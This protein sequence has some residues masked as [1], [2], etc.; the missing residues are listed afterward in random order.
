MKKTLRTLIAFFMVFSAF[1]QTPELINYQA[2]VRNATGDL[3]AE[4]T[5]GVRMSILQTTASGTAVYTETHTVDTNVNGALAVMIGGGTS[6]DQ[7]DA[8]D[9]SAG[10]Y[11]I[12]TEV[13]IAGGTNYVTIGTSQLL[14][15]PYALHAKNG[16]KFSET[17]EGLEYDGGD[18]TLT[19]PGATIKLTSPNGTVYEVGV[20][21]SG[22]LSLPTSNNPSTTPTQ[23]YLYGS[24]NNWDASTA[25]QFGY[26]IAPFGGTYVGLKYFT[27]GTEFKFLAAQNESI[28][29]GGNGFANGEFVVNGNAVVIPSNGLYR[30]T[31]NVYSN[32]IVYQIESINVSFYSIGLM[33][34]TNSNSFYNTI[35]SST[36]FSGSFNIGNNYYGD[37]LGDLSLEYN[38]TQVS[39]SA[40]TY[41]M[42]LF[43]NF[44]GSA[45]YQLF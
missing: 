39:V 30:I 33:Y 42:Q 20:N 5:V 16:S 43:L 21:D 10:P 19:Q 29:Y 7:F 11:F 45:T 35:N 34:D 6:A 23:L 40:G 12:K 32:Q 44:N 4:T 37:N 8:I 13:D 28:V 3:V 1:A 26:D 17:S 15:V 27:A 22:Q 2:V 24:F 31:V 9:W 38:G 25:L 14:S 18:I 41:I 36:P